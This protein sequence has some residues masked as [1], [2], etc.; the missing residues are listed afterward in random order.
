MIIGSGRKVGGIAGMSTQGTIS[1]CVNYNSISGEKYSGGICGYSQ[2]TVFEL[3]GNEVGS[4]IENTYGY[5]GGI[6]RIY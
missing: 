1:N 5:S 3:C 4:I 2:N 6:V